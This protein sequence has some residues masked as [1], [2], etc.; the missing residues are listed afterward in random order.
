[1]KNANIWSP[2]KFLIYDGVLKASRN[3]AEVSV[4]S[5]L[6]ADLTAGWYQDSLKEFATGDLLDLGCGKAPLY[7]VYKALVT[8]VTLADWGNSLHENNHLDVACDITKK[9]PFKNNGFDTIILSDVLEHIPNPSDLMAELKRILRPNGVVLMNVPFMYWVHEAP[10]D[11]HRY[12][13]FMLRK[14]VEDQKMTVIKL[15]ALAGGWAVL[16]DVTSKL[17]VNKPRIVRIIQKYGPKLLSKK[18]NLR[19]EIPLAYTVVF[20][21]EP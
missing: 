19:K 6:V 8:S 21:K 3:P 10:H 9:L 18:Y 2:T 17:L 7:G 15:D 13:E 4:G 16:L 20:R 5:R 12:T 1:M 11:Y 14:L